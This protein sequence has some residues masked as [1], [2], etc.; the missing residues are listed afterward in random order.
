MAVGY[1]PSIVSDGLVFYLDSANS[2]SYSGSGN[3][4]Y[5]LSRSANTSALTNGPSY[6]GAGSSSYISFD[7]SNDYVNVNSNANILSK[8]E[9]TKAA[10]VY[11][12][13]FATS[14]NIISGG[15]T[16]QHAFWMFASN[17]LNAGHN[18]AWNTVVGATTFSLNR[19]YFCAVTYSST[20]GWK[21]Y[22]NGNQDGTSADTTTFTGSQFINIGAYDNGN[23]F[24]GRI[25]G[26]LVY[27]RALT[28]QE[29]LQNY[30]ATRFRYGL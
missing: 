12:T 14:N 16:A 11:I 10:Y 19:W 6:V 29:I 18:G 3:S 25:A 20:S 2:R 27:N 28:P 30:N 5:D 22:L 17:K 24:T 4:W 1:N 13:N 23:N 7:G 21:L 9:Y 15:N 26:A 8:T